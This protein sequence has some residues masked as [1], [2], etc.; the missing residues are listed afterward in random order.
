LTTSAPLALV[1][2]MLRAVVPT[3]GDD[4]ALAPDIERAAALVAS[5]DIARATQM[6]LPDFTS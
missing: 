6:T 5:G 3:L 2:A 4:R 1:V